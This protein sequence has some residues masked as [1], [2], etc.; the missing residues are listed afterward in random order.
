MADLLKD[1]VYCTLTAA[2][3]GVTTTIPVND[4]SR[5]P[6]NAELS[7]DNFWM[8]FES[9]LAAG[10]FEIV[11]IV[12]KSTTSGAG[13]LTV[14]RAQQGTTGYSHASGTVLKH[15]LTA[16]VVSALANTVTS[17]AGRTGEV[18]LTA[19]DVGPGTFA[20]GT[21]NFPGTLQ[22]AGNQVYSAGNPPPAPA[23]MV[24]TD[25]MQSI[26]GYK[27]FSA[28]A[29]NHNALDVAFAGAGNSG[30]V[31]IVRANIPNH[32]AQ[33]TA[34]GDF[35]LRVLAPKFH[36]KSAS[37]TVPLAVQGGTGGTAD[38]QRWETS[39][40]TVVAK[41]TAAGEIYEG[42]NR[43]YSAGNPPP[44]PVT[45]VAGRTGAVTLTAADVSPGAYPAGN[46]TVNGNFDI[47]GT[48]TGGIIRT[49]ATGKRVELSATYAEYL[50][51]YSGDAAEYAPAHLRSVVSGLP[52][53]NLR[54]SVALRSP[55]AGYG[56][57]ELTLRS[58]PE[59]GSGGPSATL[60]C[61]LSALAG[62][63]VSGGQ[64]TVTGQHL[65]VQG[66]GSN[67]YVEGKVYVGTPG[68]SGLPEIPLGDV[69]AG[70]PGTTNAGPVSSTMFT[71]C[72]QAFAAVNYPRIAIVFATYYLDKTVA[73]DGFEVSLYD[74]GLS[75]VYAR[76][77]DMDSNVMSG[78]LI[79]YL[80]IPANTAKT[81]YIRAQRITGTGTATASTSN[82]YQ[83]VRAVFIPNP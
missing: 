47:T 67:A 59:G 27:T 33:G 80:A 62:V 81:I 10:E 73:T 34:A 75:T 26:S 56:V 58:A 64:L 25:T 68:V 29:F 51:L 1:F 13:N 66:A 72:S 57:G 63:D 60:G 77:R 20:A 37:D 3:D 8:T 17:V 22:Q 32:Y 38:L 65:L 48:L 76:N 28:A 69:N 45:S 54:L 18:T 61:S 74:E 23:T 14:V 79:T 83:N 16:S 24:T 9:T 5:L 4:T 44:Y 42:T 21:Y 82:T 15:A 7:T 11:R 19:A 36:I 70:G 39:A 35:A 71:I 55:D 6:T 41:V 30:G 52:G 50:R 2:V 46:Y 43:V 40:G 31:R 78:T 12:S 53:S 49:A